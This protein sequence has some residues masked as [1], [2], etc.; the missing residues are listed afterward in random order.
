MGVRA[1]LRGVWEQVAPIVYGVA[2]ALL[3]RAFL[4]DSY[5]VPS[6][7]M[8][9]TLLV[10]DHVLVNRVVYGPRIPFTDARLPGLRAPRRGEV[11]VFE[12]GE[13][14]P[15]S[16]CPLDR[17]PDAP[18]VGFV[19]RVVGL[20]GDVLEMRSGALYLNGAPLEVEYPGELFSDAEGRRLRRGRED[21]AGVRH[22]VL[23]DPGRSGLPQPRLVVPEGR[24]FM[25]GDN[26]DNSN[27]SRGWGTVRLEN[28]K[29]PVLVIYWSWNNR[30]SWLSMLNPLTWLR[31]LATETRWHRM[32]TLFTS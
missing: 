1:L 10:G 3:I 23:D 16:F 2:L 21:L 7:S 12:L 15:G 28:I 18:A 13:R 19:K 20:P 5:Y 9:P 17:C 4:L 8:L 25:L 22:A 26:R 11:V 29:G 31:L 6:E 32:G 24:Y 30:G 27:D 14:G